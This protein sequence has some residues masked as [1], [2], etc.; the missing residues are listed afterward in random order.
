MTNVFRLF[1][2]QTARQMSL[3]SIGNWLE[4]NHKLYTYG[5]MDFPRR[6]IF[7]LL[8]FLDG[9]VRII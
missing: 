3:M 4:L 8:V 7:A 9:H 1:S 2:M 5:S 6:R